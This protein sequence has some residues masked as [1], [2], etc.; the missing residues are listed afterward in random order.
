MGALILLSAVLVALILWLFGV[1]PLQTQG[2][3]QQFELTAQSV[4]F[5]LTQVFEPPA[6]LLVASQAWLGGRT[7]ALESPQEF[8]RQF[9][10]LL[11]AWP[12][13]TSVVAGTSDGQGWMLLNQ[14]EG[15]WRNRFSD[16]KAW[17]LHHHLV[18][19]E[20]ADGMVQRSVSDQ[21]YDPRLRPWFSGAMVHQRPVHWTEPY[22]FFTTGDPGITAS[23]HWRLADGRDFVMGL[24]LQL[25]DLSRITQQAQ[26]GEHGLALVLAADGRVLA[27]PD[28][29][30]TLNAQQRRSLLLQPAAKLK[31]PAVDDA[32]ARWEA[33]QRP[34]E[35]VWGFRTQG[36]AWLA[37]LQPYPLGALTL[38]VL[39][40]APEADFAM[41]W[42]RIGLALT[43]TGALLLVLG[44]AL[45]RSGARR[46]SEPLEVLAR[47]S[48]RIGALDFQATEP[49]VTQILEIEDMAQSHH[50]MAQQLHQYQAEL[51]QQAQ[52]LSA[53]L[54]RAQSLHQDLSQQNE[55]FRT[56]LDHFPSGVAV[57][58]D[59]MQVVAF[60]A[61]FQEVLA[62]PDSL[63][64]QRRFA[65]AEVLRHNAR[66]PGQTPA[67]L[68]ALVAQRIAAVNRKMPYQIQRDLA[69]G[70]TVEV[71]GMP[72]PSGGFVALYADVTAALAHEKALERMAH[73]DAL[74]QLPNRVLLADRLRQAMALV[75]RRGTQLAVAYL[76]LDGF[77]PIND[78][79]GHALG[80]Q[81]LVVLSQRIRQAL[82]D[83]DTLAR[84]G[85]DEF[86]VVLMDVQD[87]AHSA[88]MLGRILGAVDA[89]V[90]LEGLS[91]RLSASIG[92]TYY[93]QATEVDGEQLIRQADQAMYVAKQAGKNRWHAFDAEQDRTRRGHFEN[94]KRMEQ[95]LEHG[96]FVLYYQPKVQMRSGQVHGVEALI[97]WQHPERGLVPPAQFLPALEDQPLSLK[98]GEWVVRTALAQL[99][100]W[101]AQGLR[102][103]MSVN[104]GAMQLQ[105]SSFVDFLL[106]ALAEQP[107]V[108]PA[109]LML[110]VL[111][112]SALEDINRVTERMTQCRALGVQFALDDFG[113]G[114]SSLTYLKRLPVVQLKIDQSFVRDML[115]DPDDLSIL[116][117]VLDLAASFRRKAIAEGVETAAHGRLLL[118]LGC[119]CAQGYGIAR[120]MPAEQVPQW[121]QRW[122]PDPS[123]AGVR[124]VERSE[125]AV[126]VAQVEH[127]AWILAVRRGLF[128]E[129]KAKVEP[130]P[131]ACQ[132]G[133]WLEGLSSGERWSAQAVQDI[134]QSHAQAHELV[135]ALYELAERGEVGCAQ[136][137][138]PEVMALHDR[139]QRLLQGLLE[140]RGA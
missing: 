135:Q 97:R 11:Q 33:L 124:A 72:L 31:L 37:T 39:V 89:P 63:V 98:V 29:G 138:W 116:Q 44:W 107:T 66:R 109:D 106:G 121:V 9:K 131:H 114:Y 96:E 94:L 92:V 56:V 88:A 95:A 23:K 120:P 123:W 93:P 51:A 140:P 36:S 75:Q 58:D 108:N 65:F 111:E 85:G 34:R 54:A 41:D 55:R 59:D 49:V 42:G 127:H 119:D 112:T 40:L 117:G 2:A 80:D 79:H 19:D 115:D 53:Q 22:V 8:N 61:R 101:Q 3:A 68:D 16:V 18:W 76:D 45:M 128:E 99:A 1:R 47:N 13:L 91:L 57:V 21:F 50:L 130:D 87:A 104:V 103:N 77:K 30:Q 60:N 67:E 52:Q 137:R 15:R 110:E 81:M 70:R 32:L 125:Q 69:D 73:F 4:R 84:L 132:F 102:L 90:S 82:R 17:G 10:P 24:D 12:V 25:R 43:G 7:P 62:L 113:T 86:V 100:Q 129:R 38:W 46:L 6:Q 20:A 78:A 133:Q 74:T 71:R 136:A 134:R 64:R 26:I 139:L 118:Q 122:R 5:G 28:L 35:G 83:G 14:G 126:L 105:S 27:L 48:R